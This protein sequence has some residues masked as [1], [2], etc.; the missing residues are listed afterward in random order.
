MITIAFAWVRFVQHN[1]PEAH[2]TAYADNWAWMLAQPQLHSAIIRDS[3]HFVQGFTMEIDWD[4]SWIWL[5]Q[6][7][8]LPAM[9]AAIRQQLGH[10]KLLHLL[11]AMD[12]GGQ[13]TYRGPP[14]LGKVA[15]RFQEAM[16]RLKTLQRMPHD[17]RIKCLMIRQGIY[18]QVFYAAALL[19]IG[20]KHTD[21]LRSQ[22]ADALA[23]PSISRNSAI[24]IQCCPSLEDPELI[25][26]TQ[27]LLMAHRYLNRCKPAEADQFLQIAAQHSAQSHQCRGPAGTLR[28]YLARLGWDI[29]G[30]GFISFAAFRS[31]HFPSTSKKFWKKMLQ[32]AW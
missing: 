24:T 2:I 31:H 9:K 32:Q 10:D 20:K 13:L 21:G 17:I 19:P 12:L 30:K 11:Q 14:K 28:Y 8:Q 27:S 29:D 16:N 23:G 15:N 25:L 7:R 4:K 22:V 5:N 26:I 3:N 6:A 1:T 18:P